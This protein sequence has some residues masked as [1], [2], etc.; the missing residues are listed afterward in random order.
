MRLE[1]ALAQAER[2]ATWA[3]GAAAV[4]ATAVYVYVAFFVPD[5]PTAFSA[6]ASLLGFLSALFFIAFAC[7]EDVRAVRLRRCGG[8][9]DAGQ[10]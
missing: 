3:S 9:L 1:E 5:R 4:T 6:W 8:G 2:R 10:A 7:W